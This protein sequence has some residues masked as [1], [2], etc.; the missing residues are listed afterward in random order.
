MGGIDALLDPKCKDKD[1]LSLIQYLAEDQKEAK[2]LENQQV[3]KT[4]IVRNGAKATVGYVP[5]V[6]KAWE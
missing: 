3:L 1:T 2:I 4:P 5:D 6:W